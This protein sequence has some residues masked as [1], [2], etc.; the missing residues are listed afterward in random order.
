MERRET[1]EDERDDAAD[2]G[3]VAVPAN[4][5]VAANVLSGTAPAEPDA[6]GDPDN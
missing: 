3:D 6:D 2:D 1:A 5:T 4:A